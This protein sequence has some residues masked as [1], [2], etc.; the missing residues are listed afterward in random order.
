MGR[1]RRFTG[2]GISR[3]QVRHFIGRARQR[4][5]RGEGFHGTGEVFSRDE[6]R[7]FHG[8]D[9]ASDGTREAPHGMDHANKRTVLY[10]LYMPDINSQSAPFIGS[11]LLWGYERKHHTPTRNRVIAARDVEYKIAST[12]TKR[13]GEEKPVSQSKIAWREQVGNTSI[14]MLRPCRQYHHGASLRLP[15]DANTCA[16]VQTPSPSD[17]P[18]LYHPLLCPPHT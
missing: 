16:P 17:T 11:A 6:A 5:G 12:N 13:T 9:Y 1:V 2:R 8:T 4:T 3:G 18:L 14:C 7:H 15:A 10:M